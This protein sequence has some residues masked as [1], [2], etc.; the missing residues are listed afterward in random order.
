MTFYASLNGD[1]LVSGS[2]EIPFYGAWT[3]DVVLSSADNIPSQ[4]TLTLADMTLQGFAYRTAAFSGSRSARLVGGHGGW[5]KAVGAQSYYNP[6]GVLLSLVLGDLANAVGEKVQ[7][8]GD[9]AIGNYF[10][11]EACTPPDKAAIRI[12]KQLAGANW[13][14][15]PKGVTQVGAT[16]GGSAITTNFLIEEYSGSRGRFVVATENPADWMPGRVF[17]N[18]VVTSPQTISAVRHTFDA[19]GVLRTEALTESPTDRLVGPLQQLVREMLPSTTFA[20]LYEYTVQ[21][22][23]GVTVDCQPTAFVPVPQHMIKIP[24]RGGIPGCTGKP[25]QGAR[26]YVAFANG[27]PTKP[28]IVAYDGTTAQQ[29]NLNGAGPAAARKGDGVNA[30]YLVAAASGAVGG[31]YVVA[32]GTPVVYPG[33]AAGLSAATAAA[34]LLTPPGVVVPITN[35]QITGGSGTVNIGN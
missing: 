8:A 30:G 19:E 7:I 12:L 3:A 18:A 26:V 10:V 21:G 14:I 2:I 32:V 9:S 17:S 31:A 11:R 4:C 6:G 16:R 20:N 25:A 23:D 29:V 1:R 13:W 22:T 24:M 28:L 5:M 15:D 35:G 34:N 27:D 33:T